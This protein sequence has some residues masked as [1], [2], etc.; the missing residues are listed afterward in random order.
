[1]SEDEAAR[2]RK[3]AVLLAK[4]DKLAKTSPRAAAELYRQAAAL[5]SSSS[6]SSSSTCST[7]ASVASPSDSCAA[8]PAEPE[9][10]EE[11]PTTTAGA[12][13]AVTSLCQ[14][15]AQTQ[16]CGVEGFCQS[17]ADMFAVIGASASLL[18]RACRSCG[19]GRSSGG[20]VEDA[21][22]EAPPS[23]GGCCGEEEFVR[24]RESLLLLIKMCSALCETVPVIA[25]MGLC[26]NGCVGWLLDGLTFASSESDEELLLGCSG[27]LSQLCGI[28]TTNSSLPASLLAVDTDLALMLC[29]VASMRCADGGVDDPVASSLI[30]CLAA[31]HGLCEKNATATSTSNG[32]EEELDLVGSGN[33]VLDCL[34]MNEQA[35]ELGNPMICLLNRAVDQSVMSLISAILE[36]SNIGG[37]VGN[38]FFYQNDLDV[39]Y[40]IVLRE[41]ENRT[42]DEDDFRC[43]LLEALSNLMDNP[44]WKQNSSTSTRERSRDLLTAIADGNPELKAT[45]RATTILS[46][47]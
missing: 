42:E 34:F 29:G 40:D 6:S 36:R 18:A 24:C 35:R 44:S 33:A 9:G 4:A 17:H 22:E 37:D 7:A 1:M 25:C 11:G 23:A 31:A 30:V 12:C 27:L 8:A 5:E 2:Q 16:A 38:P 14:L 39:L 43:T 10:E 13:D 26:R 46:T 47:F 20:D 15:L 3:R 28:C 41:I 45:L 32:T 21:V 19:G